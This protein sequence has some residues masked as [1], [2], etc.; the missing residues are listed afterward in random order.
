MGMSDHPDLLRRS[1]FTTS[2]LGLESNRCFTGLP[3]LLGFAQPIYLKGRLPPMGQISFVVM[4]EY[5]PHLFLLG[6]PA[7][8]V[9]TKHP[10]LIE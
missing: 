4:G 6:E 5:S 1:V 7:S 2:F 8:P 10:A 9:I 3:N